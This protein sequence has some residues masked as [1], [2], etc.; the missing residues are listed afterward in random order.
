MKL[1]TYQDRAVQGVRAAFARRIRNVLLQLPTGGGKTVIAAHITQTAVARRNLV[2]FIVHRKELVE[3]T[4]GTFRTAGIPHSFIAADYPYNPTCAVQVCSI[5]TLKNRLDKLPPPNL[6]IMDEA[7]H[8]RAAGWQR[9][10]RHWNKAWWLGLS[11]T[12]ERLDGKGLGTSFDEM[13][14]GPSVR[15]LIDQG[16]LANYKLFS[17]PGADTSQLHTRMG[18]FV[19][20]EAAQ[21]MTGTSIMGDIVGHWRKHAADLLTLGF[22]PTVAASEALAAE[23]RAAGIMALH[24]DANTP[25]EDRRQALRALAKG[26]VRVVFNVALFGEGYDL[27]ANSGLNVRVGAVIDAAPTQSLGA[28]MQRCG[29]ALRPGGRSVILDH[30]GNTLRHGAPC[31]ERLWDLAGREVRE[32]REGGSDVTGKLCEECYAYIKKQH[33][34]CPECGFKFESQGRKIEQVDGE[35]AEQDLEKL[36]ARHEY[37]RDQ[38]RAD[39]LER[40]VELGRS[41]GFKNPEGWAMHVYEARMAKKVKAD[42]AKKG[43]SVPLEDTPETEELVL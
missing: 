8:V 27:A 3:Q 35:L 30:G 5:D 23:F 39:N 4:S 22:A 16:H 13:V 32:S 31:T 24:L 9:V 38:G 34:V 28:W 15:E 26:D 33:R 42:L 6:A 12:P 11:A 1:R 17:I 19:S 2:Y 25:K 40:L 37:L 10:H 7:H 21:M 29:R 18:E 43:L 14:T 36:R 20:R 41:R